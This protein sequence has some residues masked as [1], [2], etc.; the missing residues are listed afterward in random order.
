MWSDGDTNYELYTILPE[1]SGLHQ[2]T[3]TAGFDNML[4]RWSPNGS[5]AAHIVARGRP[6]EKVDR[7]ALFLHQ[8]D[9]P[10]R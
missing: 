8:R 10:R 5:K 1:G 7:A 6:V 9:M 2:L 3:V 4:P